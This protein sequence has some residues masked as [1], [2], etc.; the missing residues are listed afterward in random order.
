V[1]PGYTIT[2]AQVSRFE[3]PT[4][5]DL[6]QTDINIV[7]TAAGSDPLML[8]F[9]GD[10]FVLPAA[11]AVVPNMTLQS[12]LSVTWTGAPP[13]P[14]GSTSTLVGYADPAD[15]SIP[16][17]CCGVGGVFGGTASPLIGITADTAG[18]DS[19]ATT[20]PVVNWT[21][22]AGTYSLGGIATVTLANIGDAQNLNAIVRVTA[23]PEPAS[24]LLLGG[25]LLA[26][27]GVIRR[28]F[29]K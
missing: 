9:A 13:G 25:V 21:R 3:D 19:D 17:A 18:L 4:Q 20:S 11:P 26:V 29:A 7:K 24:V 15:G 23:V 14:S 12:T 22:G 28:R 5:G 16:A 10:G 8:E 1:L 6:F 27:S 2:G